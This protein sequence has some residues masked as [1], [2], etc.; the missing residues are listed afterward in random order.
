MEKRSY[1]LDLRSYEEE[2]FLVIAYMGHYHGFPNERGRHLPIKMTAKAFVDHKEIDF[3]CL[4]YS[5]SING[6]LPDPKF[7][8]DCEDVLR[9]KSSDWILGEFEIFM[10]GVNLKY[11]D[12]K[13]NR[14]G[15]VYLH[16]QH[17][18]T[19]KNLLME[20]SVPHVNGKP[21]TLYWLNT[22]CRPNTMDN[23]VLLTKRTYDTQSSMMFGLDGELDYS[24]D[25]IIR[26]DYADV[27][28]YIDA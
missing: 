22:K 11:Y 7:V 5:F 28:E 20:F 26:P 27:T 12:E 8:Q 2:R 24:N 13:D 15:E 17:D 10:T 18:Q 3:A 9:G 21:D 4:A 23:C 14:E 1:I 19:A 25:E 6:E 16:V